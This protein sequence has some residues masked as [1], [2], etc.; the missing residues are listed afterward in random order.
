VATVYEAVA[1]G[2]GLGVLPC[3]LG[4]RG[5]ERVGGVLGANPIWSIVHEDLVR[6]AR[7]RTVLKFLSEIIRRTRRT[8]ERG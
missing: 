1:A 2:L 8:L 7:V 3:A 5:L 4:S 6:S